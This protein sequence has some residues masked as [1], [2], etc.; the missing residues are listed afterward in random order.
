MSIWQKTIPIYGS[1]HEQQFCGEFEDAE[2]KQRS[3]KWLPPWQVKQILN[4][5]RMFAQS[6]EDKSVIWW[7]E[8][9][10]A[11][12]GASLKE[13]RFWLLVDIEVWWFV[14]A[15]LRPVQWLVLVLG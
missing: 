6:Q 10:R 2:G 1:K 7:T 13:A 12:V 3:P 9:G 15:A 8:Q 14:K 5:W 4:I 11:S